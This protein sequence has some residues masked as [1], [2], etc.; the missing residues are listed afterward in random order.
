MESNIPLQKHIKSQRKRAI[1]EQRNYK[2]PL[3]INKITISPHLS[4]ITLKVN[5]LNSSIK[6]HTVA[7][8]IKTQQYAACKRLTSALKTHKNKSEGMEND[9]SRK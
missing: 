9:I 6:R 4:I 8:W 5:G 1:E 2:K 3:K 7:E